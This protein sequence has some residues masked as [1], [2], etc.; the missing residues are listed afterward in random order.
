MT[1]QEFVH[2]P[3][4]DTGDETREALRDAVLGSHDVM[5]EMLEAA[6]APRVCDKEPRRA[7]QLADTF[8][9]TA[10]RHLAAVDDALLPVVRRRLDGGRQMVTAYVLHTRQVERTLRSVK[11]CLYGDANA[12]KLR[13]SELWQR[14]RRLLEE[15]DVQERAIVEQLTETLS[16]QEMNNLAAKFLR[17]ERRSPTRPH[18]FSPH[19]GFAGRVSKRVW[20][21]VDGFFDQAEGRVIP[22]QPPTPHPSSDSLLTRYVL[23]TP[24]FD[25]PRRAERRAS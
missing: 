3:G 5:S 11:A 12:S 23:G 2:V 16:E 14:L 8:L 25:D 19:A 15:H 9:V 21:V 7:R 6:A 22:Y 24:G 13:C 4:P 20:S 18:P 1:I 17:I 10:C